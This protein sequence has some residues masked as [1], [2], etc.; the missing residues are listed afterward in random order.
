MKVD[1]IIEK[2]EN[3]FYSAY[4]DYDG[5]DF[6]LS[7]NGYSVEETIK[8]FLVAR[9][10]IKECCENMG[11]LFP[12]NLEFNFKYDV[13]SFLAYYSDKLSLAGLQRITGVNQGQLSHYITGKSKPGPKTTERIEKKLH[14][15]AEEIRQ[16]HFV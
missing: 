6:G 4:M 9:D 14:A 5:F 3:E 10:E 1:V 8:D 7:G 13:P 2:G 16:L 15:F 12:E 11:R